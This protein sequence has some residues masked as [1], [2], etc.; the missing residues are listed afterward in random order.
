VN[1]FKL[2]KITF[3]KE[4]DNNMVNNN[5]KELDK[6]VLA[7]LVDKTLDVALSKRNVNNG[8]KVIGI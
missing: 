4:K 7:N 6:I 5:Y 3:K 1:Y 8:S 2:F